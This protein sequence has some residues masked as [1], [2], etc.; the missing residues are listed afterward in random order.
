MS[1]ADTTYAVNSFSPT[2]HAAN[3]EGPF[4]PRMNDGGF[5]GR[6]CK[7]VNKVFCGGAILF[8]ETL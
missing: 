8:A 7:D 2:S 6:N 1:I 3:K 4:I 5:L